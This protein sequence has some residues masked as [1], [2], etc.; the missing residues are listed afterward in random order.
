MF[1]MRRFASAIRHEIQVRLL[2]ARFGIEQD[3]PDPTPAA[4]DKFHLELITVGT[5]PSA[6]R[7]ADRRRFW[8][9]PSGSEL[10][11]IRLG[12]I[13]DVALGMNGFLSAGPRC[14]IAPSV[15]EI[16]ARMLIGPVV[17]LELNL[18]E[19]LVDP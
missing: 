19:Q 17:K 3:T 15:P 13:N 12:W 7:Y 10:F 1:W 9:C 5:G 18:A 11:A 16:P 6:G 8:Q 2:I 4:N 14:A